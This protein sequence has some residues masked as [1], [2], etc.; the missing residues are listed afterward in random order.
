M[1]PPFI[2]YLAVSSQ[3]TSAPSNPHSILP[4]ERWVIKADGNEVTISTERDAQG[5]ETCR[6]P[7][8]KETGEEAGGLV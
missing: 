2:H 4:P 3:I 1:V 6:S 8:T 7:D 5:R